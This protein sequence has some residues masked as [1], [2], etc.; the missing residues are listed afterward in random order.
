M[1]IGTSA[2]TYAPKPGAAPLPR[3]I[4][5]QAVL[6]T[7]MLLRNGEQ[8]LLT[9]V[10][11]TLLLVLFG[12]VDIVDTGEGKAV[13]FLAPGILALA[14]MS[15]AF[16]GQAI[17]TGFE[18]RYGVLKRLAVSPLPRWGLMTA[19][20]LS[21]L[22]TEVLQVVLLT[23]IAFAMGWSPHGNPL[24]VLLLLVLGT[25]AFSGLG[26]LM[27]GTLKAEATL[28][29]ANLVFLL[30]LVGGGVVVPLD[31]FPDAAQS[32]L[33]LLPIA[34][35][36]DGLRDVLQHGAGVPWGDLGILAVWAVL[37]LGAAARFFRWE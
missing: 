8:L 27:A 18:R 15:T 28:A 17:A 10:I 13:D 30:L 9:V 21:V 26:L 25:A 24:A 14:V 23:V 22:V 35:L 2:G 20:T 32:V 33:G 5:A 36:S 29:A 19:K 34:A 6:E 16:T 7:K 3:M 31:K 1:S 12:S 4:A 11:P 37:G